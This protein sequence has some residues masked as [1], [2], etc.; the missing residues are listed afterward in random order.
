MICRANDIEGTYLDIRPQDVFCEMS[1]GR[2]WL[3][4]GSF[5]RFLFDRV[6]LPVGVTDPGAFAARD[7]PFRLTVW[8]ND[9]ELCRVCWNNSGAAR[10]G[11]AGFRG[12]HF[13]RFPPQK[14]SGCAGRKNTK[15]PIPK[16]F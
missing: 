3:R 15:P 13:M 5:G 6:N 11:N 8:C 12:V 10:K 16:R 2:L 4:V 9:L 7:S 1:E 14:N